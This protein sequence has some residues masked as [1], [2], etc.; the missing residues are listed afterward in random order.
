V[1]E[2][3]MEMETICKTRNAFA[4]GNV[5]SFGA[6]IQISDLLRMARVVR[7]FLTPNVNSIH[8]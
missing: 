8:I 4:R 2:A 5:D 6:G 7:E 3:E 1:E